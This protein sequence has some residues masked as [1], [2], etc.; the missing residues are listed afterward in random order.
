MIDEEILKKHNLKAVPFS[1]IGEGQ[2]FNDEESFRIDILQE[3]YYFY[4]YQL[5]NGKIFF[6]DSDIP[7]PYSAGYFKNT[8]VY[9]PVWRPC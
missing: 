9:V 1:C 6:A 8:T 7:E 3:D 4:T 5:R 2:T